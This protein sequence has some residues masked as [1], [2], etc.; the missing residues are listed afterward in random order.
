M[1]SLLPI[2][3]RFGD[4]KLLKQW[5]FSGRIFQCCGHLL[6]VCLQFFKYFHEIYTF[7]H[8]KSVQHCPV[9]LSEPSEFSLDCGR[10][11]RLLRLASLARCGSLRSP[12]AARFARPLRLATLARWRLASLAAMTSLSDKCVSSAVF[13]NITNAVLTTL[14]TLLSARWRQIPT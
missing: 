12:A 13:G 8:D 2:G 6:I 14:L 7:F 9:I 11:A 1:K 10:S 4:Q 5:R 3:T